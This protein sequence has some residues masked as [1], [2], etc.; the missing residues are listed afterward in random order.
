[1]ELERDAL[2]EAILKQY[3]EEHAALGKQGTLALLERAR[4]W[5]LS[6]TLRRGGVVV[7]PHAGVADCGHQIAAAVH[8]IPKTEVATRKGKRETLMRMAAFPP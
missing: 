7:F 8:A 6:E 3:A 5:D 4:A 2:Q 1:M